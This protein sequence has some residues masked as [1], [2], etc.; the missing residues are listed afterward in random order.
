M[1]HWH[2]AAFNFLNLMLSNLYIIT[3]VTCHFGI[4]S[5][6]SLLFFF[7]FYFIHMCIQ[8]LGHFSPFPPA[9]SLMKSLL[10]LPSS[11]ASNL[12]SENFIILSHIQRTAICCELI[13]CMWYKVPVSPHVFDCE[14]LVFPTQLVKKSAISSLSSLDPLSK[15]FDDIFKG[16]YQ[17]SNPL[18]CMSV[19]MLVLKLEF[20]TQGP[21]SWD[22]ICWV[23][24]PT[25]KCQIK[26]HGEGR[27]RRFIIWLGT[28]YGKR[29]SK[30]SVHSQPSSG[31]RQE[32]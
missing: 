24:P 22:S 27:E 19:F 30:Q 18:T 2:P 6:K 28:C 3:S 13:F 20:W 32:L 23:Q 12:S 10:I 31:Y 4:I 26:R 8:C 16:L 14:Y 15:S 5:M 29:Q 9:P 17:H 7:D 21:N 25:P 11:S 1:S